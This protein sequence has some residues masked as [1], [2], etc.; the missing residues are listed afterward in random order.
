MNDKLKIKWTVLVLAWIFLSV[1]C[2]QEA[3]RV[4]PGVESS[5]RQLQPP[6]SPPPPATSPPL[7]L[8]GL[9]Q[10][11][12]GLQALLEGGRL[13]EEDQALAQDLLTTYRSLE[14]ISSSG[15][16]E[17]DLR[18]AAQLLFSNLLKLEARY[19]KEGRPE[20]AG[21]LQTLALFSSKRKA[22][23]DSYLAGDY[24]G[25]I[26]RCMD[27]EKLIGPDS[28]T[29][30]VGLVFALSLGKRGLYQEALQVGRKISDELER[31]PGFIQ[32]RA[33]MVEWQLALG[34]RNGAIQSYEKLVDNMHERDTVLK[35]AEFNLSGQGQSKALHEKGQEEPVPQVSLTKEPGSVQEVLSQVDALVRKGD[36]ETARLLLL[37]MRLRVQDGPDAELVDQAM[38]SVDLAEEQAKAQN[39]TDT[40]PQE[41]A[42]TLAANLIEQERYEEAI[43][44]LQRLG[45]S[46]L[47]S[48][49]A[50]QLQ[51]LAVEKI[52]NRE[53]NKAAKLFLMARNT[54][55]PAKKENLF[56]SSY[57]IL[58]ALVEKYPSTPLYEKIND[59]MRTIQN[60]L[61]KLK[62]RAG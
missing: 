4:P 23:M 2:A 61:S 7:E 46:N 49:E 15:P 5:S 55:D 27:M 34:D 3:L 47:L 14:K 50:K 21:M 37:R 59:N 58:K 11:M 45:Q 33:K 18:G 19:F 60:E 51:D 52:V 28:L 1:G 26:D 40:S 39:R 20:N 48:P 44:E 35:T 16:T 53:R 36:F 9:Q 31:K 54:P 32:L 57:E 62:K 12:A 42:V 56:L 10:S 8:N 25:V 6:P 38:K 17:Q 22:V 24:Q 13:S 30:E 41:D 43:A 29:P